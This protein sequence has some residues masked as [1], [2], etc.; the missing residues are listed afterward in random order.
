MGY[1]EGNFSN[2]KTNKLIIKKAKELYPEY[3]GIFDIGCWQIGQEYCRPTNPDCKNWP[4][5]D[6]CKMLIQFE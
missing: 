5:R 6:E 4:L 3:P 2:K 1:V